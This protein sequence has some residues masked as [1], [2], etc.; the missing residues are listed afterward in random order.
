VIYLPPHNISLSLSH[1]EHKCYYETAEDYIGRDDRLDFRSA[2]ERQACIDTNEVWELQWY[3]DT[4][5]GFC[6]I[7]APTLEAL[8]EYAKELHNDKPEL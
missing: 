5:V 3:P 1:N 6:A 8:I 2:E 4:P 7:A